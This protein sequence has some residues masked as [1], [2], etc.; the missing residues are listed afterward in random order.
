MNETLNQCIE[1]LSTLIRFPSVSHTSNQAITQWLAEKCKAMGAQ[2]ELLSYQDDTATQKVS[3]LAKLGEG[4]GGVA[5]FGHSDVVPAE[6]WAAGES[7]P[8]EPRI[9]EDKLFGRGSCDMKGSVSCF[10]TAM[11]QFHEKCP[12]HGPIYFVC[13]SDEEVGFQGAEYISQNATL[14][15]EMVERNVPGIIGEPTLLNVV[16][17]HKGV[18]VLKITS[19]GVAA[20]SSSLK[21]VNANWNLIPVLEECRRMNE[22]VMNN[23]QWQNDSFDPPS[24]GWNLRVNDGMGAVNITAA[25]ST[26]LLSFRPMPG[27]NAE[28]LIERI[29]NVSQANACELEILQN[30]APF[31]RSPDS[32]W[33]KQMLEL[34]DHP[35]SFSVSYGTD[36]SCFGD[37]PE[38]VVC[39]PGSIEQAHTN[40]EFITLE[41]LEAGVETYSRIIQTCCTDENAC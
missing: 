4:T 27:Q 3:L 19:H 10:L 26:A 34:T 21:G 12:N 14:Y 5:Y 2:T 39:G 40:A 37:L 11:E 17:A 36:A 28:I 32:N 38:L 6:D 24:I 29:R 33:T 30:S 8:F 7:G 9:A 31:G 1:T 25:Q 22:D 13:T 35:Q 20:H 16:H 23:P 18:V 15:Q 41:Q